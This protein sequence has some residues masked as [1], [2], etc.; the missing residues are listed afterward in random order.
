MQ[1]EINFDRIDR[2]YS[3]KPGCMCGCRGNYWDNADKGVK[4]V[5]RIATLVLNHPEVQRELGHAF[6]TID[7]RN[8]V[9][10]FK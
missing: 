9:I 1:T 2:V 8:Y 7:G 5:K 10:Y 3:G 6:A 4:Q